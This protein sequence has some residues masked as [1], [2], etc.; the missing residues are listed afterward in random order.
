MASIW[1]QRREDKQPKK[2]KGHLHEHSAKRVFDAYLAEWHKASPNNTAERVFKYEAILRVRG[3]ITGLLFLEAHSV[4]S[5]DE[6][7]QPKRKA[8]A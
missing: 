7:G 4:P 5:A 1:I 8:T 6:P 3:K 2:L